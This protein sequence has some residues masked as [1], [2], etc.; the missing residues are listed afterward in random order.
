MNVAGGLITY[1]VI[2]NMKSRANMSTEEREL[3]KQNMINAVINTTAQ[4]FYII[5]K[6]FTPVGLKGYSPVLIHKESET[7]FNTKLNEALAN[8]N[9]ADANNPYAGVNGMVWGVKC[10]TLTKHVW[11]KLYFSQAYPL[12]ESW[13]TSMGASNA[14]WYY[15]DVDDRFMVCEW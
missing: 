2:F 14:D 8:G 13:V 15:T 9:V 7:P 6:D 4:N 10:P 1:T 5:N 12:Y 3:A 11:N